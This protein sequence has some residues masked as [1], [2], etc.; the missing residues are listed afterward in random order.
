[1]PDRFIVP[2]P[3]VYQAPVELTDADLLAQSLVLPLLAQVLAQARERYAIGQ[4]WQSLLDGLGLWQVWDLDLPL[5]S[6]REEVVKWIYVD[7]PATRPGQ[8]VVL[9][10]H[11]RELCAVH[12]LW[13]RS[14][15]QIG[16]PLL[17]ADPD[18]EAWYSTPLGLREPL[19]RLDQLAVSVPPDESLGPLSSSYMPHLGQTVALATLVEYTVATY[20]RERL[21][22]LLAGL[23]QSDSW[24]T[25]IPAVYG[26]SPAAFEA[27]WRVYLAERYAV[28]LP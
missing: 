4:P 15:T 18:W 12:R 5:A 13:L 17:C 28:S 24:D 2:S 14:P 16:I 23:G 22:A 8:S 19:I 11:H 20:G 3:A 27:G 6:W 10:A 21:P 9:P 1:V 26:V 25:L 7:W